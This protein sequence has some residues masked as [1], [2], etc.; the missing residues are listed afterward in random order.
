MIDSPQVPRN[1]TAHVMRF[2]AMLPQNDWNRGVAAP[3]L[4]FVDS[5]DLLGT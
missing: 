3:R 2:L 4:F 1:V 5:P